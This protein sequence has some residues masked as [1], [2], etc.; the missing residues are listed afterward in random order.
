M[1]RRARFEASTFKCM[2]VGFLVPPSFGLGNK[3]SGVAHHARLSEKAAREVLG[4]ETRLLSPW[5]HVSTLDLDLVHAFSASPSFIGGRTGSG[6]PWVINPIHDSLMPRQPY[7]LAASV[8]RLPRVSTEPAEKRKLLAQVDRILALSANEKQRI[9]EHF[10]IPDR[11]ISVVN[12]PAPAV[13]PIPDGEA[14]EVIRALGVGNDKFAV[15]IC[16]YGAKRK[17]IQRLVEAAVGAGI[18]LVLAGNASPTRQLRSIKKAAAEST[19]VT[20]LGPVDQREKVALMQ[21]SAL[22]CQ[23]SLEEGAG[24]AAME[25]ALLGCAVI[26]TDVGGVREHLGDAPTWVDPTDTSSIA[27]GLREAFGRG[28]GDL[29]TYIEQQHS[30]EAFAHDLGR[31]Y[32]DCLATVVV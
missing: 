3:F 18:P 25:A 5:E 13:E 1:R 21:L 4:I 26:A 27:T 11:K 12:C 15:A 10:A 8:G 32:T 30:L 24:L 9:V 17:N 19:L 14:T 16:D 28:A 31:A 6:I 2:K 22:Y 29:K 7:R 20:L 23:P